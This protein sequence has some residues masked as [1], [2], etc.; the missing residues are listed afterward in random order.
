MLGAH[1]AH[2]PSHSQQRI[3]D[4]PP[5][6]AEDQKEAP[7]QQKHFVR[8]LCFAMMGGGSGEPLESNNAIAIDEVNCFQF[9][10]HDFAMHFGAGINFDAHE[11]L[12]GSTVPPLQQTA[13]SVDADLVLIPNRI[14]A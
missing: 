12:A 3:S 2:N 7:E 6:G 4:L 1:V 14:V 9:D 5:S 8:Q 11:C 10:A 13:D